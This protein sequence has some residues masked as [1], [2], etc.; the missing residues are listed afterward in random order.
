[1]LGA[2]EG[3]DGA[4]VARAKFAQVPAFVVVAFARDELCLRVVVLRRLF[5]AE[6][7][8]PIEFGEIRALEVIV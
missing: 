1:M 7:Y 4:F 5:F 2:V 3:G 6:R 8:Q